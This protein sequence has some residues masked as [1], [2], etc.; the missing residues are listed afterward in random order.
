MLILLSG[1][2]LC[3]RCSFKKFYKIRQLQDF[4]KWF[5]E[6]PWLNLIFLGLTIASIVLA[7]YLH[8][9][10]IRLKKPL[11]FKKSINVISDSIPNIKELEIYYQSKRIINLTV[12]KIAIWNSGN[13]TITNSDQA[14]IDKMRIETEEGI[15]IFHA[16]VLH[17]T[18][19]TN[20]LVTEI[21]N[22]I[23]KIEFDYFDHNQ[24]G[25]I[26][27]VHAGKNS[28]ALDVFG[29]F[30]S[31][32][33]I[34]ETKAPRFAIELM[35]LFQS[36]KT[37]NRFDK[38]TLANAIIWFMIISSIPLTIPDL[39]VD[40]GIWRKILCLLTLG[41]AIF[42]GSMMLQ[43]FNRSSLHKDFDILMNDD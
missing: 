31:V 14:S 32:G 3:V 34:K 28:D 26:K 22:N 21:K 1:V 33:R 8:R 27:V 25:I 30:K 35:G 19:F 5:N 9:K 11:Y 38:R 42:N 12:T 18:D 29:T 10:N 39:F 16:C 4:L 40:S 15:E 2:Y 37:L 20:N 23:V 7:I 13:E 17:Q 43:L 6:N 41:L 24:G 36:S